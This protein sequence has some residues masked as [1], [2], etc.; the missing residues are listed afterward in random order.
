MRI[1]SSAQG[2]RASPHHLTAGQ[3][4]WT[5][6]AWFSA[7]NACCKYQ[8]SPDTRPSA[9]CPRSLNAFF[10]FTCREQGRI[11]CRLG[12]IGHGHA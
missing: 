8:V 9:R 2:T 1:C 4:N 3:H 7:R 10:S 11:A 5:A 12:K 6:L